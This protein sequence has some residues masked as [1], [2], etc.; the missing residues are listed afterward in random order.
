MVYV[1]TKLIIVDD[2]EMIIG[3]Q[4]INDRSALSIYDTPLFYLA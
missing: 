1:H 2:N 3:S 4:N